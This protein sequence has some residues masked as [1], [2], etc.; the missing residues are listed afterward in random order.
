VQQKHGSGLD[1]VVNV[2]GWC[3]AVFVVV[4]IRVSSGRAM[5]LHTVMHSTVSCR[6]RGQGESFVW[7]LSK[8]GR[9]D[10]SLDKGSRRLPRARPSFLP[11]ATHH[12]SQPHSPTED[13][14]RLCPYHQHTQPE[15][16]HGRVWSLIRRA[17]KQTNNQPIAYCTPTLL[18][19]QSATNHGHRLT[20][21]RLTISCTTYEHHRDSLFERQHRAPPGAGYLAHD[22]FAKRWCDMEVGKGTNPADSGDMEVPY[23]DTGHAFAGNIWHYRAAV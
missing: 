15:H 20:T 1:G 8:G 14:S 5:A 13:R 3:D 11:T 22:A 17:N 9:R 2:R 21:D 6:R 4:I 12:D 7:C 18:I 23:T 16:T 10:G 19:E